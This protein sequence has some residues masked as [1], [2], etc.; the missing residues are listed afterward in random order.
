M[1]CDRMNKEKLITKSL[2]PVKYELGIIDWLGKGL[3]DLDLRVRGALSHANMRSSTGGLQHLYLSRS[4]GGRGLNC[5][6]DL[7]VLACFRLNILLQ[8]KLA[9]LVSTFPQKSRD[10][11]YRWCLLLNSRK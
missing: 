3:D 2:G 10:K 7:E 5:L 9:W 1:I 11:V 8:T 4:R 6:A